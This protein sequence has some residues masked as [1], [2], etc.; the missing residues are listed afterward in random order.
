MRDGFDRASPSR[1]TPDGRLSVLLVNSLYAPQVVGGA[2]TV[3]QM[4][5]TTLAEQGHCA[6]VVA[7][8]SKADDQRRDVEDGVAIHRFFPPNLW[9]LYERFLPG[10]E[11]TRLAK[12]RWRL[13]DAW[14]AAAARRFG[15]ILDHVRP[16]IVHTHNIKGL[17]PAL[18]REVK[19]RGIPL[20]HTAHSYELIC[21]GGLLLDA[22]NRVC[23]PEA[24]CSPCV[25]QGF[26]YGT[27]A[28]SIDMFCSPSRYLL[29]AHRKAG[30]RIPRAA[31]VRN[32]YRRPPRSRRS[33]AR[34]PGELRLLYLGQL[35]PHKGVQTLIEAAM[36]SPAAFRLDVAGQGAAAEAMQRLSGSD[37]RI[38]FHGFVDGARKRELLE[39]ADALIFP[40]IWVENAPMSMIEALCHGLPV[41]ASDIG[42]VPEFIRH[43][44]NGLLFRAG[45]P[46]AL[47]DAIASIIEDGPRL[48][49]LRDGAARA[50]E[51]MPGPERMAADYMEIYRSAL[52]DA[53]RARGQAGRSPV[54][55]LAPEVFGELP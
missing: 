19:R 36:R 31:V 55:A 48:R 22:K 35:A 25:L 53:G 11:K 8:C 28:R 15:G 9:W 6:T 38:R 2:E 10:D 17:S 42:A 26:W 20:V 3:T 27:H 5:A 12:L 14:N 41:I 30:L 39:T 46:R 44:V 21:A 29:D 24:R 4:L 13:R 51:E 49:R 16:D 7:S 47:A 1:H 33:L 37:R 40:S 50:G 32:G 23:R 54:S 45:D 43:D 52:R 34:D 18:W